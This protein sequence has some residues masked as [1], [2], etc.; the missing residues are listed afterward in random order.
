MASGRSGKTDSA[1]PQDTEGVGVGQFKGK[2]LS[3]LVGY[4]KSGG[5][6]IEAWSYPYLGKAGCCKS[7]RIVAVLRGMT[8]IVCEMNVWGNGMQCSFP[9]NE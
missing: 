3:P 6:R 4:E 5:V 9:G 1:I 7:G 8:Y 2:V